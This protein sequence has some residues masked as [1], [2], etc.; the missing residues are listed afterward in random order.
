MCAVCSAYNVQCKP[1]TAHCRVKR[2]E[3]KC[4]EKFSAT[5]LQARHLLRNRV[6][7]SVG[8]YFVSADKQTNKQ[9]KSS[10]IYFLAGNKGCRNCKLVDGSKIYI[11]GMGSYHMMPWGLFL[12]LCMRLDSNPLALVF[13][14]DWPLI[15][16][17]WPK[18][19]PNFYFV[20]WVDSMK[21]E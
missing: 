19:E 12:L 6:A 9:S 10:K 14:L 21:R 20:Y 11:F 13:L 16:G 8:N 17:G 15:L 18:S 1:C 2:E 7:S 4:I 3:G 5:F